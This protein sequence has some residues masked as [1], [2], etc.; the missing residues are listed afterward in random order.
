M[1]TKEKIQK[2]TDISQG[3]GW[4]VNVDDKDKSNIL[5]EFQHYTKYGQDFNFNA[6]MSNE[7]IETLVAGIKQYFTDFDP[8]YEASL[9]IGDDGHGKCGAPY[10]IK[11][12]VADM[13]DAETKIY[14]LLK[15]LETELL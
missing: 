5:F 3:Y 14:E 9:W 13:E 12:I 4:S 1:N 6:E 11:D 7:E 10:H 2:V 15:A 8:D